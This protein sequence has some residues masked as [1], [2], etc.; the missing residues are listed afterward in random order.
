MHMLI[1]VSLFLGEVTISNDGA[2][3]MKLLDIVHP[4][5]KT[6]VDIARSQDAEVIQ[7]WDECKRGNSRYGIRSVMVPRALYCWLVNCWRKSRDI[8]KMVS[9]LMSLSKDT[10][11]LLVW[12]VMYFLLWKCSNSKL[13]MMQFDRLS[14]RSR[15]LPY[16]STRTI[17]SKL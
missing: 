13:I 1:P 15:S 4:A 12:Y 3:I 6:L 8:L 11:M 2:T 5:A 9:A 16:K 10:A 17:K 14:T 7:K